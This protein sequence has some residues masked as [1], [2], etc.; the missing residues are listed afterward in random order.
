MT[1]ADSKAELKE[2]ILFC[3]LIINKPG[4][5][6]IQVTLNLGPEGFPGIEVPLY[7]EVLDITND[8]LYP[9]TV[10]YMERTSI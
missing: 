9:L 10:K 3:W 2:T 7:N 4:P 1:V 6:S 8:F 5:S